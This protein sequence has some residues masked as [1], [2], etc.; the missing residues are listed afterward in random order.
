MGMRETFD[1]ACRHR[2][3]GELFDIEAIPQA[4]SYSVFQHTRELA[5]DLI[6]S[7]K[8]FLPSLPNIHFDFVLDGEINAAAFKHEGNYFIAVTTGAVAMLH[9]VVSRIMAN[10]RTFP[11]IGRP[12]IERDDLP[13]IEWTITDAEDLFQM[14]VRPVLPQDDSRRAYGQILADQALMFLVGHEIAHITRGH[15]DYLDQV[16]GSF[17]RELGWRCNREQQL[18]RQALELDA[19][20]R[21]IFSRIVSMRLTSE[22]EQSIRVHPSGLKATEEMLQYDTL[23]AVNVLFRLFGDKRFTHEELNESL[24]PPLP[25]RRFLAMEYARAQIRGQLDRKQAE[26]VNIVMQGVLHA[27]ELSFTE[28]GAAP[29]EGGYESALS[30]E[31]QG[32]IRRINECWNRLSVSLTQFA[33]EP[34]GK[35]TE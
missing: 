13:S 6:D 10:P 30:E 16:W 27:I 31:S 25:L 17:V 18:E 19:D 2:R 14:G 24:Y 9:L 32:H 21:A 23:F 35:K 20:R 28:I 29:Q 4:P 12:S 7:A 3:L 22:Q 5:V 26:R 11:Q 33:Y 34:V 15:V 1:Q 8:T